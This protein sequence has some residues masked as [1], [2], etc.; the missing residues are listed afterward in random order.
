MNFIVTRSSDAHRP[1]S[2]QAGD[3]VRLSASGVSGSDIIHHDAVQHRAELGSGL[4]GLPSPAPPSRSPSAASAFNYGTL[5]FERDVN[6][7]GQ[8][9]AARHE[10]AHRPGPEAPRP[11]QPGGDDLHRRDDPLRPHR[12]RRPT[13]TVALQFAVAE[14][15]NSPVNGRLPAARDS[16]RR[17]RARSKIRMTVIP[18]S[19][20]PHGHGSAAR[21]STASRFPGSPSTCRVSS[22]RS[23]VTHMI[24]RRQPDGGDR[25]PPRGPRRCESV[26]KIPFLGR[27]ADRPALLF[28]GT[29]HAPR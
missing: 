28:Q 8:L 9:P 12:L 27:P 21:V 1:G 23:L 6:C 16:A 13:R 29:Q 2:S 24:L 14:D 19:P 20:R 18:G 4:V 10:H 11:R 17:C 22:P 7:S 3:T 26:D 25:R 15:P 5:T